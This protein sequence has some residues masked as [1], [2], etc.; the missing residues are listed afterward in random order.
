MTPPSLSA[1]RA[2]SHHRAALSVPH[3]LSSRTDQQMSFR[4][5]LVVEHEIADRLGSLIA[6]PLDSRLPQFRALPCRSGTGPP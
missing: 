4:T 1:I 6:L 2:L 3:R 5:P